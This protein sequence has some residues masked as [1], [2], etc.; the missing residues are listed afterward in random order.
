MG[1]PASVITQGESFEVCHRLLD[2][3]LL[4]VASARTTRSKAYSIERMLHR[5][6][7]AVVKMLCRSGMPYA[8]V[9]SYLANWVDS[10][11]MHA[12]LQHAVTRK[13]LAIWLPICVRCAP[14][15]SPTGLQCRL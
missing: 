9:T 6:A 5:M 12:I 4:H 7:F 8:T 15:L 13:I 1:L 11:V 3:C 10:D 14:F 2:V